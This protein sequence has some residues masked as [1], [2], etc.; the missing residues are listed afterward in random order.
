MQQHTQVT[1]QAHMP[2]TINM[3][4]QHM[5]QQNGIQTPRA[6]CT[7]LSRSSDVEA[8]LTVLLLA[9]AYSTSTTTIGY[10]SSYSGFRLCVSV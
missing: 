7:L 2:K 4:T 3:E 1:D 10:S 5:K 6:L 9:Q 8:A